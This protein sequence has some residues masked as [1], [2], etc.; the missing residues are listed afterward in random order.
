MVRTE[1]SL[2]GVNAMN[3]PGRVRT[4]YTKEMRRAKEQR[5][6]EMAAAAR[7]AAIAEQRSRAAVARWH[8]EMKD[9]TQAA[10]L[11]V[12]IN[13]MLK[14]LIDENSGKGLLE[15]DYMDKE[16]ID[17]RKAQGVILKDTMALIRGLRELKDFLKDEIVLLNKVDLDNEENQ[18]LFKTANKLLEESGIKGYL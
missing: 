6:I 15:V 14:Q 3:K 5:Q 12:I 16:S 10:K 2:N 4:G 18:E 9:G 1:K 8:P 17:R 13:R 7:L 11:D